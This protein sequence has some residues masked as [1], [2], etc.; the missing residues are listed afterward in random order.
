M[1]R[2][3]ADRPNETETLRVRLA[4]AEEMLR[5]IQHGE[6]DALV[7]EGDGGN[8][9]YTLHSAEEPYR[10]LVEQMQE[11]AVVLT[12]RGDILYANS[13][14]ATL[15][16][17]PLES[18]VG[19]RFN[20]FV[21]ASERD[22]LEALLAAGSGRRRCGLLRPDSGPLGVSLSLTTVGSAH[23]ERRNLIVTDMTELLEAHS[24]CDRAERD[25]RTKDEFLAMLAHELR[26][27]LA[28]IGTAA[29]VLKVTH[30]DGVVATRAHDVIARQVSH[31]T[32]LIEDLLDIERVVSGKI[33]LNR[34]PLD[35]ADV[36][37]RAVATF[38]D[39]VR[40]DRSI[41]AS[42]ESAWVDGD[43]VRIEQVLTN[44]V[45]NAVKYTPS[46]GR[47]RVAVR[48]DGA[49]AV[50]TVE[51]SGFGISPSLLPFIFDMYVQADQTIERARGGLGIGLALVRRL[52]ELHGGT[53]A[54]SSDG[55]GHGSTFSVRLTKI[56]S[57]D[58]SS[59]VSLPRERRATP[60]RVLL[61]EDS[62]EA[63][64]RLRMV[65]ELA[66]HVVYDTPDGVRGIELLNIVRPHVGIIDVSLPGMDGYQVARRIREKPQGRG[67]L[68]LALTGQG[69]PGD[70]EHSLEHGFDYH[71]V[72]PV[73]PAYLTRLISEGVERSV[74]ATFA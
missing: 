45:A 15:V 19:S 13:R 49:D 71:L 30:T 62:G 17:V 55:E 67:M 72:K 6:I 40:L 8:Q 46:G 65:L 53:V 38:I 39:D 44:L 60:R 28:A 34:Q 50:L 9:V 14:F 73:D 1:F 69:S 47:I 22:D 42:T 48:A 66:G 57:P 20:R 52:V 61:I 26:N 11:G 58:R 32:Q 2:R 29:Q 23:S 5:A 7:V 51:D 10:D 70:S 18:V 12:N 43:A 4:E 68:L 63:R 16:G 64:E 33:R 25:S 27:P 54:A 37:R 56:P 3:H 36:V 59:G 74:D 31:I 24:N 35:L 41:D 21:S